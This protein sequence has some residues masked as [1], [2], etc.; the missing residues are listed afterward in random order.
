MSGDIPCSRHERHALEQDILPLT[1]VRVPTSP[2]KC[3]DARFGSV[4]LCDFGFNNYT[5]V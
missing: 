2:A 5:F 3:G 1:R 4:T